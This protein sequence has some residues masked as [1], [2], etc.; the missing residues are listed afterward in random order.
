MCMRL[1]KFVIVFLIVSVCCSCYNHGQQTTDAWK[2]SSHF[3]PW[4]QNLSQQQLDSISFSTTH[5][6]TQNYNFLVRSELLPLADNLGDMAFDTMYVTK[7]QRIVVADI[8]TVP[9]DTIDSVWVKVARDQITQ[10]WIRENELLASVSPDD[11]ISQFIDVFS[12]AHLLVFLAFCVVVGGVYAMRKLLRRNA[13][14][15]HFNDIDSFYP[16]LLCILMAISA[17]VYATIQTFGAEQWRHYYFHPS[18]NPFNLPFTL[19]LFVSSVW[20]IIIVGVAAVDDTFRRL[21]ASDAFLYLLGL[22]AVCAVLYVVFSILTLYYVGYLLLPAYVFFALIRW[23]RY[24][25]TP[26]RCGKCGAALKQKGVCPH[27]GT[28]NS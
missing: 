9:T 18:L 24:A 11:P 15:V 26:Y 13:Y 12:D 25:R 14:I 3:D 5:H 27:C 7:G 23:Y 6:Y 22:G 2:A 17:T 16:T 19:G 20:A 4:S 10:G 21:H 28:M 1:V 8:E